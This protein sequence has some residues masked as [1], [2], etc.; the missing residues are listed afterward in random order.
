MTYTKQ[1]LLSWEC[2]HLNNIELKWSQA[3]TWNSFYNISS[4]NNTYFMFLIA[5]IVKYVN[6]YEDDTFPV[7]P[8]PY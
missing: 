4:L 8:T 3:D 5:A 6:K 7:P 1:P 2:N